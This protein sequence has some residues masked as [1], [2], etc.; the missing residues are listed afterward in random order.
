VLEDGVAVG[1]WDHRDGVLAFASFD[2]KHRDEAVEQAARAFRNVLR[3]EHIE[4]RDPPPRLGKRRRN[5]YIAPL[6]G[7]RS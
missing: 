5:D 4:R 2:G 1:V 6:F 3:I 7:L